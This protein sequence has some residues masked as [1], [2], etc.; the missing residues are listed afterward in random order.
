MG[1]SKLAEKCKKCPKV[2]SCDHKRMEAVACLEMPKITADISQGISQ[3]MAMP[4]ARE[5][6]KINDGHGNMIEVYKDDIAKQIEQQLFKDR[7][8]EYG[9]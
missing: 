1:L 4:L 9:A 8:F 2:D 5:T 7:F 3:S 6:M